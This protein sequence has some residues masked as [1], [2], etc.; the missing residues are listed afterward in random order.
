[1]LAAL[2]QEGMIETAGGRAEVAQT[3]LP[4]T[5]RLTILRRLSFLPDDMLQAL[6]SA[7]ILGTS[8]TLTD[9][10]AVT[11]TAPLL[12][13]FGVARR[14]SSGRRCSRTTATGSGSATT[15]SATRSTRICRSPSAAGCTARPGSG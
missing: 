7:S 5:L 13:L 9:L 1:M 2:A 6:R 12:E 3:A 11:M 8:F 10:V 4:P 14:G 15:S